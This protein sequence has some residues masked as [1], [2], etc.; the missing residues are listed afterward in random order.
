MAGSGAH[1]R[2]V[3]SNDSG[4]PG[5]KRHGRAA[6]V[7]SVAITVRVATT[8]LD[9][10]SQVR[11]VAVAIVRV[12]EVLGSRLEKDIERKVRDAADIVDAV[13]PG[14]PFQKLG[15]L[16]LQLH[17]VQAMEYMLSALVLERRC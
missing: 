17:S 15:Q 7:C 13:P 4:L 3:I 8:V 1:R 2:A 9:H 11:I 16:C 6:R 12:E 10:R 5:S 14:V